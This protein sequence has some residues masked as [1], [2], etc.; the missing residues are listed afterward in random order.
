MS[1]SFFASFLFVVC[2]HWYVIWNFKSVIVIASLLLLHVFNDLFSRTAWVSWNQKGKTSLHLHETRDYGV[3][4]CSGISWTICKQSASCPW[5]I[6]GQMLFLPCNQQ[7]QRTEDMCYYYY[8]YYT[9]LT[10]S[11]PRQPV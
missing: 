6:T 5:Q 10:A 1:L 2:M 3:L 4:G 9:Y 8:W 11:F 7:C